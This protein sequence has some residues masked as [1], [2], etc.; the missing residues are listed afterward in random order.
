MSINPEF[1]MSWEWVELILGTIYIY[2]FIVESLK[3]KYEQVEIML[4]AEYSSVYIAF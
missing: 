1:V 4:A 2:Y 3:K